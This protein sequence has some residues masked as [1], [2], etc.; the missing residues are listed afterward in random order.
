MCTL[1]MSLIL[2]TYRIFKLSDIVYLYENIYYMNFIETIDSV[3]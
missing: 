1:K 2:P 3:I